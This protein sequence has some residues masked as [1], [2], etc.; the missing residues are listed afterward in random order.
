MKTQLVPTS[1][2]ASLDTLVM[3]ERARMLM[4]AVWVSK[5]AVTM[6]IATML[7]VLITVVVL[8]DSKEMAFHVKMWMNANGQIGTTAVYMH[9]AITQLALMPVSVS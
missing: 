6:H 3:D 7:L 9:I 4:N 8:M 1:A 2:N 5:I